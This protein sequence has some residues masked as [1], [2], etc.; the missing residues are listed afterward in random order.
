MRR[1]PT[2]TLGG[3]H[4]ARVLV[5]ADGAHSIVRHMLGMRPGPM[6]VALRGYAPMPQS[7][8]G[9]ERGRRSR[10]W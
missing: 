9:P 10:H 4:E 2:V 1:G 8:A 3:T 6:A 7:R 5:G